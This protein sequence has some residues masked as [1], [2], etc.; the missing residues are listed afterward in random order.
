MTKQR[1]EYTTLH[2]YIQVYIVYY[3]GLIV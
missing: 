2:H 1:H 3:F